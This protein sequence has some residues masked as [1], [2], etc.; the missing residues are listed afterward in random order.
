MSE[1]LYGTSTVAMSAYN[2]VAASGRPVQLSEVFERVRDI[3][4]RGLTQKHFDA[5]VKGL[6]KRKLVAKRRGGLLDV[7]DPRNRIVGQRDQSDGD[8]DAKGRVVGGWNGWLV[9]DGGK[10]LPI[11]H[12][13]LLRALKDLGDVGCLPGLTQANKQ[14]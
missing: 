8:Y 7:L 12:G 14:L 13:K 6:L 3:Q 2:L 9:M 5:A 1:K 4:L 10:L 11:D